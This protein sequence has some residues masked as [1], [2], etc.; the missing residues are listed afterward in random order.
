M[1]CI[2]VSLFFILQSI[3]LPLIAAQHQPKYRF[4][5]SFHPKYANSLPV[6][7]KKLSN[8]WLVVYDKNGC[9]EIFDSKNDYK[10]LHIF[11]HHTVPHARFSNF[12]Y[13]VDE[14]K[15]TLLI[16]QDAKPESE[17]LYV[18]KVHN[19]E[20]A[21]CWGGY[22]NIGFAY[23]LYQKVDGTLIVHDSLTGEYFQITPKWTDARIQYQREK[24]ILI[25]RESILD[26]GFL[27]RD[28]GLV[29][30][31]GLVSDKKCPRL[32]Q[33]D[34]DMTT[35]P[36]SQRFYLTCISSF[37]T[38]KV[39]RLPMVYHTMNDGFLYYACDCGPVAIWQE[40]LPENT[41]QN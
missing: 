12:F 14:D 34:F 37:G 15:N 41:G 13:Y 20:S 10:S 38:E 30:S 33:H 23:T 5:H 1:N 28:E 21:V 35:I 31:L 39:L 7:I 29:C 24:E 3:S 22:L 40:V 2:I 26:Q 17:K 6:A 11:A 36:E 9:G 19:E 16:A 27:V 4:V 8:D 25:K 18:F 32:L